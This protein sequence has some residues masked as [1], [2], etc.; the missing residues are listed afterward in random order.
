M[1]LDLRPPLRW[2]PERNFTRPAQLLGQ[3]SGP[4]EVTHS[5]NLADHRN[6]LRFCGG[7]TNC[8]AA[9]TRR[10]KYVGLHLNRRLLRV[11]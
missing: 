7:G 10:A 8:L 2:Y 6:L 5:G 3:E 1:A 11:F 4:E 9:A